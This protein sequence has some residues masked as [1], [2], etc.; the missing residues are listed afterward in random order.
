MTKSLMNFP[1]LRTR[2]FI[3]V[4]CCM[5]LQSSLLYSAACCFNLS[6]IVTTHA[7]HYTF[8]KLKSHTKTLKIRPYMFRS[9]LK[10]SSG[11]HGRILL[12]Y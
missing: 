6:F 2:I 1:K 11:V 8:K 7:L 3:V 9:L 4:Q 10:P 5:L 12:G